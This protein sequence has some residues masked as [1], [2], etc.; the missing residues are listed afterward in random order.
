MAGKSLRCV[1]FSEDESG[2]AG[3]AALTSTQERPLGPLR[4]R[5]LFT[6]PAPYDIKRQVIGLR[7]AAAVNGELGSAFLLCMFSAILDSVRGA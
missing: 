2:E 4:W 7:V 1:A 3:R 6:L 5:A